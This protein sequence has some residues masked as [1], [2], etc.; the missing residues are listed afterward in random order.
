MPAHPQHVRDK[1]RRLH[2]QGWSYKSIG[3]VLGVSA[4]SVH[5]WIDPAYGAS[6]KKRQRQRY[7]R[8]RVPCKECG[9]PCR[10]G[11]AKTGLCIQ[12]FHLSQGA[13]YPTEPGK[14]TP[15]L[16]CKALR[17]WHQKHGAP[18]TAD[19]WKRSGPNRP[20]YLQVRRVFRYWNEALQ[21]AGLPTNPRNVHGGGHQRFSRDEARALRTKGVADKEIAERMGVTAQAIYYAIGPR[22]DAFKRTP[23]PRNRAER[24]AALKRA[25]AKQ[26]EAEAIL[27]GKENGANVS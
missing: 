7:M 17:A 18:P 11:K 23:K 22:G 12:C 15:E 21:A 1:A 25:L 3:K 26:E 10:G 16:I 27:G 13:A 2:K 4:T 19:D 6:L 9:K 20:S 24:E 14:W 8:S 5:T